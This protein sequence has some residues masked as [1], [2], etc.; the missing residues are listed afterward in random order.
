MFHCLMPNNLPKFLKHLLIPNLSLFSSFS[1]H[2]LRNSPSSSNSHLLPPILLHPFL[3][4]SA[5][6]DQMVPN[7]PYSPQTA[8]IPHYRENDKPLYSLIGSLA[9]VLSIVAVGSAGVASRRN[10]KLSINER[11]IVS[12]YSICKANITHLIAIY[13]VLTSR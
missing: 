11:L 5:M 3:Y 2:K 7:H 1:K 6:E 4:P 13:M 12:W 9:L 10:P 8:V